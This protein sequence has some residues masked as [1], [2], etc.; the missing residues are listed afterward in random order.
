VFKKNSTCWDITPCS[1]L[2]VNQ[3]FEGT[4]RRRLQ[5]RR[6]S[7]ARNQRESR[8][9]AELSKLY[10]PSKRRLAFKGLHGVI[11]QKVVLF[12]SA[13]VRET[14]RN[15]LYYFVCRTAGYKSVYI[16]KVLRPTIFIKVFLVF[17]CLQGN[18]E[19]V[20]KSQVATALFLK[21]SGRKLIKIKPHCCRS[22]QNC[23][24]FPNDTVRR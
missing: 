7:R 1:S 23:F 5:G 8:W 17:L 3:G 24:L 14:L 18:A 10:V 19:M 11:S 20:P 2:K 4:Y 6:I 22:F 13:Y 15:V 9:Q 16:R 21:P 12:N